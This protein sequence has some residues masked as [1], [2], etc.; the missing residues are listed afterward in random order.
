MQRERGLAAGTLEAL[1]QDETGRRQV[2]LR[3]AAPLVMVCFFIS[4]GYSLLVGK[5]ERRT[6]HNH[7]NPS[8]QGWES[9]GQQ[10]ARSIAYIIATSAETAAHMQ[11][12]RLP[13]R[14]G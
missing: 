7:V 6:R 12:L 4:S 8:C 13:C 5:E 9:M 10:W 14:T 1:L 3:N 11:R 2:S